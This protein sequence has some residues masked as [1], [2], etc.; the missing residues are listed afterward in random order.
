V[1]SL[2]EGISAT[3]HI[4]AV[5]DQEGVIT[6]TATKI[7]SSPQDPDPGNDESFASVS[8]G[9]AYVDSFGNCSGLTPCYD[10]IG[11]GIASSGCEA[12]INISEGTYEESIVLDTP[13]Q[14]ILLG[15]WD[16]SFSFQSSYTTINR[17][18]IRQGEI[19]SS[20]LIIR[21]SVLMGKDVES[22][23][24]NMYFALLE[25]PVAEE[26]L[27]YWN[28]LFDST[29]MKVDVAR[30]MGLA[31]I[32]SEEFMNQELTSEMMV[33]GVYQGFFGRFPDDEEAYSWIEDMES[34]KTTTGDLVDALAGSAEFLAVLEEFNR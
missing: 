17:L 5:V 4:S 29:A 6:N 16:A 7:G 25:R 20:N 31:I 30:I 33:T 14:L 32:G 26:E 9:V 23:I 11:E 18:V 27:V 10:S 15:G 8:A 1:G 34:G 21:P 22:F 13:K 19:I 24:N 2:A 3:L 28:D 12:T